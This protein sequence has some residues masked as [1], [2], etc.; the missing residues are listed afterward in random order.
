MR[1]R[2]VALVVLMCIPIASGAGES[3][4]AEGTWRSWGGVITAAPDVAGVGFDGPAF[5][6]ARGTDGALW[7]RNNEIDW[8][9]LGGQL[10][11]APAAASA[12]ANPGFGGPPDT[13]G[14]AV[15]A[16]GLDNALWARTYSTST[17]EWTPWQ[18]L[19]GVLTSAPAAAATGNPND[20]SPGSSFRLR[21]FA[22]GADGALW[23]KAF[24]GG[25]WG[26]WTSLGGLLVGGPGAS[27]T[28][29]PSATGPNAIVTVRGIDN[30]A[31]Y[32]LYNLTSGALGPWTS[33]GG[34]LTDDPDGEHFCGFRIWARGT[35]DQIWQKHL[36]PDLPWAAWGGLS[37]SGPAVHLFGPARLIAIRGTDDAL[38]TNTSTNT[39]C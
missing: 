6:F 8:T 30:A 11:G 14:L 4:R 25:A 9:S 33:A 24:S 18:S 13:G 21:V 32:R 17:S 22:R 16:R 20:G 35:D 27:E 19:G 23:Q 12:S 38:W 10:D 1:R 31:W 39:P 29:E 15:F 2:F 3:A 7:I 5:F 34:V 26:A 28:F 37:R 36:E